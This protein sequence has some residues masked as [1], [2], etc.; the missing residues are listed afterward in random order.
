MGFFDV[1]SKRAEKAEKRRFL[2]AG[3]PGFL[4]SGKKGKK[5]RFVCLGRAIYAGRFDFFG[6]VSKKG[7]SG[8]AQRGFWGKIRVFS[9]FFRKWAHFSETVG[10]WEKVWKKGSFFVFSKNRKNVFLEA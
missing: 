7:T 3:G 2:G 1:F 8:G 9:G 4:S 6:R 10:F 5:G